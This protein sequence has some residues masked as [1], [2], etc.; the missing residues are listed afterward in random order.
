MTTSS[1]TEQPKAAR[2]LGTTLVVAVVLVL[3]LALVA[4]KM[5]P[6][7]FFSLVKTQI[8]VR[9]G[10]DTTLVDV[11]IV[12]DDVGGKTSTTKNLERLKPGEERA[13]RVGTDTSLRI[14]FVLDGT[15]Q[16]HKEYVDLW[17]GETYAFEIQTDG[18]V[19][20]GYDHGKRTA[21]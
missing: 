21:D 5:L 6:F 11:E 13:L 10:T 16:V 2:R 3:A 1:E 9:N 8:V 18:S 7:V 17:T 19:S 12:L 20:S 14:S 15:R 4:Y